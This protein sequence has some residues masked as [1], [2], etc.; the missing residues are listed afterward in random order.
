MS[1]HIMGHPSEIF[2][3]GIAYAPVSNFRYYCKLDFVLVSVF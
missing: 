1:S 2:K 3:C